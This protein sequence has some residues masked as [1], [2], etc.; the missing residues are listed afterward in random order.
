MENIIL[1][2]WDNLAELYQDKFINDVLNVGNDLET[3]VLELARLVIDMTKSKS[4]ILHLP[5]LEEGD[6][7]RRKPD[8]TKMRQLLQRPLTS[9]EVGIEK[10]LKSMK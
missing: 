1:A 3:T 6:M 4:E 7:T 8:I 2:N 9:L 10:L 5:A